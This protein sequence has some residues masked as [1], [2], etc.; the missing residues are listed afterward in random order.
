MV[1]YGKMLSC[2]LTDWLDFLCLQRHKLDATF[3]YVRSLA[4]KSPIS[5]AKEALLGLY[6]DIAKKVR[7]S[8]F[9]CR[10]WSFKYG[11]YLPPECFLL[12]WLSLAAGLPDMNSFF[13]A[14]N[15]T[16][17]SKLFVLC[18]VDKSGCWDFEHSHRCPYDAS[19]SCTFNKA[20]VWVRWEA[21]H[22]KQLGSMA[23]LRPAAVQRLLPFA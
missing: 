13:L 8:V 2:L 11:L 3:F 9:L 10:M 17:G 16:R 7:C 22:L 5:S 1:S 4:V 19:L 14:V 18:L 20:V 6:D 23:L 15:S 12:S 21:N